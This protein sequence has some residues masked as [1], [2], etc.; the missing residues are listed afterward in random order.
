MK[1]EVKK[2]KKFSDSSGVPADECGTLADPM[3]V[4]PYSV[5]D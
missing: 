1:I 5:K 2:G 3:T 4:I